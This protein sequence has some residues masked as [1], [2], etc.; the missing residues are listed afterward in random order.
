MKFTGI[1]HFVLTVSDVAAS[2]AFYEKLG[3]EIVTFGDDRKAIRFGDQKI[4]LHPVDNDVEPVAAD[5]TPGAGDVCLLTTTSLE[6]VQRQL[7]EHDVDV[8]MGPIDRTGAVGPIRS[9]YV[10]D[11]DDNLVEIGTYDVP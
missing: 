10:R 5:P 2:C 1:D 6:A 3:A 7:E 9:V 11:P 4:N 8:V